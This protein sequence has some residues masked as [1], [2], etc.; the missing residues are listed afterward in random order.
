MLETDAPKR[1]DWQLAIEKEIVKN[2][3][4]NVSVFLFEVIAR[5]L[6]DK[7]LDREIAEVCCFLCSAAQEMIP[8]TR[9]K[10]KKWNK[11]AKK[12]SI[13]KTWVDGGRPHEGRVYDSMKAAKRDVKQRLKLCKAR[14][15]ENVSNQEILWSKPMILADSG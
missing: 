7:L 6:D 5:P 2:Y 11:K 13:M 4:A 10:K 3:S 12:T 14:R 15:S 1:L 9:E 8:V